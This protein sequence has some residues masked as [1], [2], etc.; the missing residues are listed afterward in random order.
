MRFA[1]RLCWSDCICGS[2]AGL[3]KTE[4]NREI[5]RAFLDDVLI[6]RQLE[7]L[8]HYIDADCYTEHNPRFGDDLSM[9]RAAYQTK[10]FPSSCERQRMDP[11]VISNNYVC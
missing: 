2:L 3:D 7:K 6:H 10:S 11:T 9:L 8:E 5:V 4:T 1:R